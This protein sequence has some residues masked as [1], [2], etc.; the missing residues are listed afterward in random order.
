MI[1]EHCETGFGWNIM[2]TTVMRVHGLQLEF[3]LF[4]SII[5]FGRN[6]SRTWKVAIE[7]YL[8][9]MVEQV[10]ITYQWVCDNHNQWFTVAHESIGLFHLVWFATDW[11]FTSD[12]RGFLIRFLVVVTH[13][14]LKDPW[15]RRLGG[16]HIRRSNLGVRANI[17]VWTYCYLSISRWRKPWYSSK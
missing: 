12:S 9:N 5:G 10:Y 14:S 7:I 3:K 2:T 4:G 13:I 17:S 11:G 8:N 1:G 16:Y 15:E 6:Q